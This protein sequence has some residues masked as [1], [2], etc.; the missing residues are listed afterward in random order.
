MSFVKDLLNLT[1]KI[2]ET[3][4]KLNTAKREVVTNLDSIE[5]RLN[6]I[7]DNKKNAKYI[8][9]KIQDLEKY[10]EEEDAKISPFQAIVITLEISYLFKTKHFFESHLNIYDFLCTSLDN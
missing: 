9:E 10:L 1:K 2:K 8:K 3:V 5:T 6:E 4:D 7:N